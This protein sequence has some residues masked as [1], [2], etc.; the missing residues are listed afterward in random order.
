MRSPLTRLSAPTSVPEPRTR[1]VGGETPS[2]FP[3]AVSAGPDQYAWL[4]AAPWT[5]TLAGVCAVSCLWT[6]V[7]GPGTATF[8]DDTSPTTSVTFSTIGTYRL[9]LTADDGV[10]TDYRDVVVN[11][12]K[13]PDARTSQFVVEALNTDPAPPARVS[14][15]V[16][17]TLSRGFT[18]TSGEVG[19]AELS[20][21]LVPSG[22]RI[23]FGEF[24]TSSTPTYGQVGFAE[25]EI[26]SHVVTAGSIGFTEFAVPDAVVVVERISQLVVETLTTHDEPSAH[27]SQVVAETLSTH[28]DPKAH[29][30]QLVIET[31]SPVLEET[32][33]CLGYA[34]LSMQLVPNAGRIGFAELFVPKPP[35]VYPTQIAPLQT[36]AVLYIGGE[37][38]IVYGDELLPH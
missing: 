37:W 38:V 6:K 20:A 30:S 11:I 23:S 2:V 28:P 8:T 10:N 32:A 15:F 18:V 14:H 26:P 22:G 34:E 35:R 21:P 4:Y 7:W 16:V 25:L 3:P 24:A 12:L 19:F 17:E 36:V 27:I 29:I 1:L 5:V 13:Y 33:G 31:L 9:R